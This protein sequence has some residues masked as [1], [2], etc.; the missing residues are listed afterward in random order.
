MDETDMLW[1]AS[2]EDGNVECKE[3]EGTDCKDEDSDTDW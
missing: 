1:N 2:E 3:Y